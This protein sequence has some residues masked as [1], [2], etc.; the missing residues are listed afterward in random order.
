MCV[1]ID[2]NQHGKQATLT[3]T[4]RQWRENGHNLLVVPL[5]TKLNPRASFLTFRLGLRRQHLARHRLLPS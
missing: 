2:S 5:V 3:T 4:T 1:Y